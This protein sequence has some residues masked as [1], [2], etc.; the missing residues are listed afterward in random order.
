MMLI[1]RRL[2]ASGSISISDRHQQADDPAPRRI[3]Q[4]RRAAAIRNLPEVDRPRD[5]PCG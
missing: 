5:H 1:K 2:T 4:K 3:E